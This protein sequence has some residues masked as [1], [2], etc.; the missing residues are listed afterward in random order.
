MSDPTARKHHFLFLQGLRS[1]F[2]WRLGKALVA[3][4]ARVTKV[5]FTVGDHLYWP[6]AALRCKADETALPEY[7][8]QLF[9]GGDY[10]DVVLFGD[11]RPVHQPAIAL[12]HRLGLPVHVFEEGYFRPDW[13]TLERDGVNAHSKLPR[14][15]HWYELVKNTV[16]KVFTPN[17]VGPSMTHRVLHDIAYNAGNLLNPLCYPRYSSHVP[18]SIPAEYWGYVKR[19]VQVH[20]MRK[21][22]RDMVDRL[23]R[24][25][26]QDQ[27]PY[28]LVALQVPGDTQLTVHS[29]YNSSHD[30]LADVFDSFV[31]HAEKTALLVIKSHPLDPGL[32]RSHE[33]V[34][35]LARQHGCQERTVFLNSGNLPHL[36]DHAQ[37]LITVNSTTIGQALFHHCPTIALG[38]SIYAMPGLTFQGSLHD[39][40]QHARSPQAK[41]DQALYHAFRRVV[42]HSTQVNGGLYTDRGMRLAVAHAVPNLL[43]TKGKLQALLEQYPCEPHS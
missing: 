28:Y 25:V 35:S 23:S 6:G 31:H 40:W 8:E 19:Y 38:K 3:E 13:I 29:P 5:Q 12:A 30:F 24:G 2:F 41:P 22:D 9:S 7:Y 21:R 10:T 43:A 36:L 33:Q 4:G 11:C 15:P 42:L 39:F 27:Q 14:D 34:K 17:E 1:P 37:G 20:A 32:E 26:C 18:H 16:A